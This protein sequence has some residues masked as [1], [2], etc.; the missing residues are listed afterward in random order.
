MRIQITEEKTFTARAGT[1]V[2]TGLRVDSEWHGMRRLVNDTGAALI[3]D[4]DILVRALPPLSSDRFVTVPAT[5]LPDGS[6]VP[7]FRVG[8]FLAGKNSDGKLA[9]TDVAAPWVNVNYADARKACETA[10]YKLITERQW[11]AMAWNIVNV[12]ANWS[13][14][15]IGQGKL[16]QG[17]RL[18]DVSEAKPGTFTPTNRD[19]VRWLELS[20]GEKICDVNGNAFQ[21]VFD[22]VQGD[23]EGLIKSKFA[24]DSL[25]LQAPYGPNEK[26]I[27]WRPSSTP[28]WSGDALIRG[29]YWL[30]DS[31]AG[32][33]RLGYDEPSYAF[34]RVG[35]RCTDPRL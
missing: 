17:I 1:Q 24:A 16:H 34:D 13:E 21:W 29:G 11:L 6:I 7:E 12:D 10:G 22:D 14:G 31:F 27:G 5:K 19:E 20:T 2:F 18:G 33:F 15:K 25:S 28:D 8:Q 4:G 3:V 26:G 30:S 9:I 23:A 35:F 32:V